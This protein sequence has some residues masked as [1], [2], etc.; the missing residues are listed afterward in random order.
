MRISVAMCTYN[1][2]KY[3]AEQVESIVGQTVQPLELIV[4]DDVS[5]D[6]TLDILNR[7]ARTSPFPI[8][9]FRNQTRLGSTENFSRAISLCEGD[10][11]AL[12][13]QDDVWVPEKLETLG[14]ML[15]A[16]PDVGA[17]F[18]DA[19]VVDQ[20]LQPLGYGTFDFIKFGRSEQ[21]QVETGRHW[22][23]LIGQQ[24]VTGAT[25]AF[26]A[27][28][29]P[30][31]L[32]VPPS[33]EFMIHDRWIAIIIGSMSRLGMSTQRLIKYR[34]HEN[35]QMGA[36]R[37][38]RS[39]QEALQTIY[40][41]NKSS[42]L[43]HLDFLHSLRRWVLNA[44]GEAVQ[45]GFIEALDSRIRHLELRTNLPR[46]R[47]RRMAAV[48]S[49]LSSGAYRRFSNGIYSAVKDLRDQ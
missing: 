5:T 20:N 7:L 38:S 1:G 22:D 43:E 39:P 12:A 4:C 35:Q 28:F 30:F 37:Q 44:A 32:P 13:D 21:R 26:R 3:L 33:H 29:K 23:V 16:R 45:P 9:I 19:E 40:S 17:V 15:E 8:K 2:A 41:R 47:W 25:L 42:Y 49:E 18:S 6:E 24:F 14:G 48:G 10:V 46:N 36:P 34:Q 11:I 27:A 31:I